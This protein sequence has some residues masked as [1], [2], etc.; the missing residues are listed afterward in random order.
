MATVWPDALTTHNQTLVEQA[1]GAW[2]AMPEAWKEQ[3]ETCW[4]PLASHLAEFSKQYKAKHHQPAIV[5][6]HGGQ[7][8][9]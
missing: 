3:L 7:G 2:L 5:G 1:Q 9:G 8:S 4:L 6:V